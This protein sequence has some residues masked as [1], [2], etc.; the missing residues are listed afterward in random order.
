MSIAYFIYQYNDAD[1]ACPITWKLLS[2][3]HRV[4]A[5]ILNPSFDVSNDP[6]FEYLRK[7]P[8]FHLMQMS[9]FFPYPGA[10]WLFQQHQNRT[11]GFFRRATRKILREL[12][13][14]VNWA[15]NTLKRLNVNTCIFDWGGLGARNRTEI[16]LAAKSLGLRTLSFPQG[17]YIFQNDDANPRVAEAVKRGEK[18]RADYNVYDAYVF[19][20]TYHRDLQ[21][22]LGIDETLS[23]VIG[24]PRYCAEWLSINDTFN[25]DFMPAKVCGDRLKVVIMLQSW[26][27]NLDKEATLEGIAALAEQ[28]WIYLVVKDRPQKELAA[29]PANVKKNLEGRPNVE[30]IGAGATSTSLMRWA[31][32]I[33]NYASGVV[34]EAI[35]AG[36]PIINPTYM[37]NNHTII[38]VTGVSLEVATK[39]ELLD[40]L[41]ALHGSSPP[42]V[43]DEA[44]QALLQGAV[45]GGREPFDV[46]G[47]YCSLVIEETV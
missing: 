39:N 35:A 14:S 32:T 15:K 12:N 1:Q 23:R 47:A 25:P 42:S 2:E 37:H 44:R 5:V 29:L 10:K 28:D 36:K 6:R 46:L 22:K 27:Y 16:L 11:A 18:P 9:D 33:I 21:V 24:S 43:P 19:Q 3:G 41:K 38:D 20:S 34:I 13:I 31:D 17:A 30:V 4:Y 40:I 26:S 45:Y 8:E 7:F